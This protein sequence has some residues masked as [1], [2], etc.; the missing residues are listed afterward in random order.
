MNLIA[1]IGYRRILSVLM[2]FGLSV[3][4]TSAMSTPRPACEATGSPSSCELEE[5]LRLPLVL[6]DK[7]SSDA[8]ASA[9]KKD[10][11]ANKMPTTAAPIPDPVAK[12]NGKSISINEFNAYYA[13]IM[14]NRSWHGNP[15]EDQVKA[16]RKEV[17]DLLI[18]N[19]LL[20]EE[21]KKR[22]FKPDED[23]IKRTAADMEE[24]Y[25]ALPAWQKDRENVL[26]KMSAQVGR[27]SLIEQAKK[28]LHD[29]PQPTPAQVHAYYEQKSELFTEPGKLRMSMILLKVDPGAPNTDWAKRREEAQ[30]LYLRLKDGASFAEL[31][32][33]YSDDQSAIDGGDLGYLHGGMLPEKLQSN[34]A[35]SPVGVVAEPF[36]MLEGIAVYRLDE[37]VAPTLREFTD[38]EQRA[39]ELLERDW[40]DQAWAENISRLRRDAN[41]EIFVPIADDSGKQSDHGKMP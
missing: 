5:P 35:N 17:I 25:G 22:G 14:R 19:E 18:E 10:M 26:P 36:T 9:T 7:G 12:V 40:K 30:R 33:Q 34:I 41:I 32:R 1:H 23:T 31:A 11:A 16:V 37:R 39:Q 28:V 13:A 29:I 21:A 3:N 8:A 38:V 2:C 24:R 20:V 4:S 15:S 27:T 6:A